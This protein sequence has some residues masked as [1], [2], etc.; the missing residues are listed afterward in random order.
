[1]LDFKRNMVGHTFKRLEERLKSQEQLYRNGQETALELV[2]HLLKKDQSTSLQ[3]QP[4][5]SPEQAK[6][7]TDK[8]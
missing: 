4:M 6:Q 3:Q 8:L 5:L 7:L 2:K 1:M